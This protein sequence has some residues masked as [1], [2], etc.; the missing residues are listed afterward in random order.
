MWSRS[1]HHHIGIMV[2]KPFSKFDLDP[3][4]NGFI[5]FQ[6][7]QHA[8]EIQHITANLSQLETFLDHVVSKCKRTLTN[9]MELTSKAFAFVWILT[10]SSLQPFVT[11]CGV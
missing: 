9:K 11:Q 5:P 2:A 4:H 8:L 1:N 3:M 6:E 10:I 7:Q